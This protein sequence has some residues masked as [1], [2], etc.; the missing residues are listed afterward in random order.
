M[1]TPSIAGSTESIAMMELG[2]HGLGL[3]VSA[4]R[5]IVFGFF[6]GWIHDARSCVSG[7]V[8]Q[9]PEIKMPPIEAADPGRHHFRTVF[10]ASSLSAQGTVGLPPGC[11]T[12]ELPKSLLMLDISI[13]EILEEINQFR[14][15]SPGSSF[16]QKYLIHLD[17]SKFASGCESNG[18][19]GFR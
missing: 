10:C 8:H 4:W 13:V 1:R 15:R 12:W 5:G 17:R 7:Y 3:G 18:W 16:A 14:R 2:E 6:Q 11:R 9:E 19:T